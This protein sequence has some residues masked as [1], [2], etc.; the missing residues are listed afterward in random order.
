MLFSLMSG[1]ARSGKL[2]LLQLGLLGVMLLATFALHVSGT[3]LVELR[4]ARL[5]LVAALVVGFGWFSRRRGR[6][7]VANPAHG[8]GDGPRQVPGP[9]R[10][11]D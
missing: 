2:M 1:H 7:D 3:T 8:A 5:V 11:D 4:I 9:A 6:G 10:A